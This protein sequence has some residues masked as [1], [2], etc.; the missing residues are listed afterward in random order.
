MRPSSD[1]AK[2]APCM[3]TPNLTES[4]KLQKVDV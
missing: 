4:S 2:D 1:L 3:L